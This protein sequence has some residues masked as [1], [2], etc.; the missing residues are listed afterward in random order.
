MPA[1]K[2]HACNSGAAGFDNMTAVGNGSFDANWLYTFSG[3]RAI[4]TGL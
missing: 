3:G 2:R 1:C 4:Q